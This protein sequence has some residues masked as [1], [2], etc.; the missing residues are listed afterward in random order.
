MPEETMDI[1]MR[2]YGHIRDGRPIVVEGNDTSVLIND[3][4]Q[5]PLEIVDDFFGNM[6]RGYTVTYS[7][8]LTDGQNRQMEP[9]RARNNLNMRY[10][11][12]T[13]EYEKRVI[14]SI[15]RRGEKYQDRS[16][17]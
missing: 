4:G 7:G 11:P 1:E 6:E 8:R 12:G 2:V 16:M 14:D 17:C 3:V 15:P 5:S 9:N 10:A 13:S